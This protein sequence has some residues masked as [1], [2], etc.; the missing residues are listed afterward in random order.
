MSVSF[1]VFTSISLSM[2]HMKE[3]Q[4]FFLLAFIY[5]SHMTHMIRI[6]DVY[7]SFC[8]S[9]CISVCCISRRMRRRRRRIRTF[10]TLSPSCNSGRQERQ[11][12]SSTWR[13]ATVECFTYTSGWRCLYREKFSYSLT[14]TKQMIKKKT[15][16][17]DREREEFYENSN[18]HSVEKG[19]TLKQKEHLLLPFLSSFS[20]IYMR[21]PQE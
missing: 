2:T 21:R 14:C 9:F 5:I 17:T 6:Q 10:S 11:K 18:E 3:I 13:Q 12:H 8:I 7:I 15:N 4:C 19:R 1:S 20:S 16:T